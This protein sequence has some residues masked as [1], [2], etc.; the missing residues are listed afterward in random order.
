LNQAV[1]VVDRVG[2]AGVSSFTRFQ[3]FFRQFNGTSDGAALV[4]GLKV[5]R[6]GYRV[7]HYAATSLNMDQSIPYQRRTKR[8]T[9][10]KRPFIG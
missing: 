8:N 6:I 2:C 9:R 3:A 1:G 4:D 7:S 10:I 5:L